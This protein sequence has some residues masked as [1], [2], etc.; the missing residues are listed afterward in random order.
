MSEAERT[1]RAKCT[2]CHRTYEPSSRD[3]RGWVAAVDEMQ[4]R[5]K[6]HLTPEERATVLTWLTGDPQGKPGLR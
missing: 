4:A 2:S 3:A 1:Y 6:V 5:K